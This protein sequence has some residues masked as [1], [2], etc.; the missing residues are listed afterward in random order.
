MI[1]FVDQIVEQRS[2]VDHRRTKILGS[3]LSARMV[4]GVMRGAVMLNYIGKILGTLVEVVHRVAA[5]EHHF[6]EKIVSL[7]YR[8][9]GIIDELDLG[10]F[11]RVIVTL[12]LPVRQHWTFKEVMS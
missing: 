6:A 5:R 2:K 7:S 8:V 10:L 3:G 1:G 11:Y 9:A 12:P 4:K